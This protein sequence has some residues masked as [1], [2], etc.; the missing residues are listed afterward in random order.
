MSSIDV[1]QP[2]K[3][4][5]KSKAVYRAPELTN[6][7]GLCELTGNGTLF[8]NDGNNTCTGNASTATT[9]CAS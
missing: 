3:S 6:Y 2:E 1:G 7:G 4:C 5:A 8:G 9:P